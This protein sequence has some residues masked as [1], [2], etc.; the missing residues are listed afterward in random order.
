MDI[1]LRI[2]L[3]RLRR[4]P[5]PVIPSDAN[6]VS[7][8]ELNP[9]WFAFHEHM[10]GL[11]ETVENILVSFTDQCS[12]VLRKSNETDLYGNASTRDECARLMKREMARLRQWATQV[13]AALRVRGQSQGAASFSTLRSELCF[14]DSDPHW[15]QRQRLILECQYH[16]FCVALQRIFVDFSP[17]P[18]FGTLNSD[19]SCIC[20]VNHAIRLSNIVDQA[21]RETDLLVGCYQAAEWAQ[22]ALYALAGFCV[23]YPVSPPARSARKALA[24]AGGIFVLYGENND[25]TVSMTRL[26]QEF[27]AR[28]S[29]IIDDFRVGS[30]SSSSSAATTLTPETPPVPSGPSMTT[31]GLQGI[32]P[33]FL[34]ESTPPMVSSIPWE[35]VASDSLLWTE[36]S[37]DGQDLWNV[38]MAD[39]YTDT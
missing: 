21:N 7:F 25:A 39:Y 16:D 5:R 32:L 3:G 38:W 15:L 35:G 33:Q 23:G 6:S 11:C 18:T 30:G 26:A 9:D 4:E 34:T 37:P 1:R 12:N 22:H 31:Q 2:K 27:D 28:I 8:D 19:Q 17:N 36:V 13:P 14:P 10:T 24:V 29:G 20:C